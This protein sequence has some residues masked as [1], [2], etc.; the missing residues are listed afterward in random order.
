M[1]IMGSIG[2]GLVWGWLLTLAGSRG[3]RIWRNAIWLGIT[4]GIL[5][6]TIYQLFNDWTPAIY[7]MGATVTAV[8]LHMAFL[9]GLQL[10]YGSS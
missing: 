5:A 1:L 8:L 4:T 9:Q 7:F 3:R 2:L 10:R 6:Y